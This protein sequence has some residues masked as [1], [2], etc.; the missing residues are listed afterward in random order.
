M[1]FIH[2][3]PQA[4]VY[5]IERLGVFKTV[6]YAG[7]HFR[8]PFIEKVSRRISLKEQVAD[9]PPQNVITKDNCIVQ[10]DSVVFF[11]VEDPEKF[12]YKIMEPIEG[13]A[14]LV[15]TTLRS[16]IGNLTLEDTMT[17]REEINQHM[18]TTLNEST[19]KWGISINKVEILDIIPPRDVSESMEKQIKAEREKRA[20]ILNAE[21]TKQSAILISE[22]E[23]E[24]KIL[25]AQAEKEAA[26]LNAQAQKEAK[27]LKAQAEK[28]AKILESEGEAEAILKIQEATAEGIEKINDSMPSKE[29]LTIQQIEALKQVGTS[30]SSKI[31]IPSNLQTLSTIGTV[32]KESMNNINLDAELDEEISEDNF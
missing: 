7:L 1:F 23:K 11:H 6:W 3:V 22:G 26:I 28:E 8:I 4:S 30:K 10:I 17:S 27:L 19:F 9:F 13:I 31:I 21:A 2:I 16:Y 24:A 29:Y 5:V 12:T 18:K 20:A 25:K 14:N 15:S 32:L